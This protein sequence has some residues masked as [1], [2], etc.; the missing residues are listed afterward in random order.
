MAQEAVIVEAA[1]EHTH[2][3]LAALVGGA[4]VVALAAQHADTVVAAHPLGTSGIVD[5]RVRDPDTLNLWVSGEGRWTGAGLDVVG[6]LA[7]GVESTSVPVF[8]GVSAAAA[9]ANLV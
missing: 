2:A 4:V 8:A 3:G 5:A 1:G 9:E 6:R 7:K